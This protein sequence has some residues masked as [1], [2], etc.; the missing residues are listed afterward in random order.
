MPTCTGGGLPQCMLGYTH[1]P[2]AELLTHA[3]ENITFPQLRLRTV[4]KRRFFFILSGE[5]FY[6]DLDGYSNTNQLETDLYE[7]GALVERFFN[8]QVTKIITN[9]KEVTSL[10]I[11]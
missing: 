2:W 11:Y 5:R 9:K 10:N 1:S 8:N 6:L 7:M 3:C 4:V